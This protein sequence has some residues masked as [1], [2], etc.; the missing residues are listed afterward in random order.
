MPKFYITSGELQTIVD[1]P[2]FALA[3]KKIIEKSLKEENLNIGILMNINEKG[4]NSNE[5]I[6]APV[7]PLL[8]KMGFEEQTDG[9]WLNLLCET[10][11]MPFE[12]LPAKQVKWLLTGVMDIE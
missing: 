9:E 3:A 7:I 8:K 5:V 11:K 1:A 4:F 10:L 2:N 12:K 6:L